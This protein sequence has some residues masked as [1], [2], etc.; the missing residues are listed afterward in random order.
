MA[1]NHVQFQ[2]GSSHIAFLALYVHRRPMLRCAL[3]MSDGPMRCLCQHCVHDSMLPVEQPQAPTEQSLPPPDL[4]YRKH[5]LRLHVAATHGV[6]PSREELQ[7]PW[8]TKGVSAMKLHHHSGSDLP[9]MPRRQIRHK[10]DAASSEGARPIAH[11]MRKWF[12]IFEERLSPLACRSGK[13]S[14]VRWR[15]R[16][17]A[18]CRRG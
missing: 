6:V 1:R 13:A 5:Y 12:S 11:P 14:A 3:S 2:K 10:S 8:S 16:Q 15:A 17:D 18:R 7:G 9:T 4:E